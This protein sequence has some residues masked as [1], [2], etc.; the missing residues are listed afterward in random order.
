MR[1][2]TICVA[3]PTLVRD[4]TEL[5]KTAIFKR[6]VAGPVRVGRTN[7][8][9]NGQADLE[10]HG[11]EH[12]AVYAY[13][14]DHYPSW[15]E[16]LGRDDLEHGG[17]GENLTIEGLAESRAFLGDQWRIGS[18]A[19]AITQPRVPCFKLGIRMAD[20]GIVKRFT[21]SL[22]SGCYL[23]VLQEGTIAAG[24][25]VEVIARGKGEVRI[26][27]LFEA[28]MLKKAPDGAELL[29]RALGETS[30]SP[31]WRSAIRERLGRTLGP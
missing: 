17:F 21:R 10:N 5:V 11:G 8:K 29:A 28:L 26:D 30:L 16:E 18:A 23:M 6:P 25:P 4:G 19:F 3:R 15:R 14:A 31:A 2:A 9:G 1:L 12:M 20:P 24:D 7:L 22:R 13:S 27:R